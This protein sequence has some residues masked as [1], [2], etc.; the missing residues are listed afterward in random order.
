MEEEESIIQFVSAYFKKYGTMPSVRTLCRETTFTAGR[1]Y[2]TFGN[3]EKLCQRTGI[4]IDE[5]TKARIRG[6]VKATR[7]HVRRSERKKPKTQAMA[8]RGKGEAE[9]STAAPA[10]EEIRKNVEA[11]EEAHSA[12]IDNVQK[13]A[14]QIGVLLQDPNPEISEPVLEAFCDIIPI[15]LKKKH[16][17]TYSVKDLIGA[18][19]TLTR[20]QHDL[21]ELAKKEIRVDVKLKKSEDERQD[22]QREWE[23]LKQNPERGALLDR[24]N[25]LQLDKKALESNVSE[26]YVANKNL[27]VLVSSLL[28]PITNCDTCKRRFLAN[29]EPYKPILDWLATGK[30]ALLTFET[31]TAPQT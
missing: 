10:Y 7:K 3:M 17:V 12:I 4:V 21:Q 19:E 28:G 24:I 20:V 5:Q 29:M 6:A 2:R 13:F 16:G 11:E 31:V 22:I 30:W 26:M 27:R 8:P 23:R 9:T 14:G 15:I 1:F 25:E 18:E